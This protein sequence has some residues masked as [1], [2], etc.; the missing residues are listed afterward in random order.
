MFTVRYLGKRTVSF[1]EALPAGIS[2]AVITISLDLLTISARCVQHRA[3]RLFTDVASA[4]LVIPVTTTLAM[5]Y[6][7]RK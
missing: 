3:C 5:G 2:W 7:R 4:Y 1:A 6:P